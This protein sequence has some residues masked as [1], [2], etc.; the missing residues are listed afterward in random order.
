MSWRCRCFV[1]WQLSS[2]KFHCLNLDVSNPAFDLV[3][4]RS[5]TRSL[6]SAWLGKCG[7]AWASSTTKT[8]WRACFAVGTCAII[9]RDHRRRVGNWKL[10]TMHH[11]TKARPAQDS[12]LWLGLT[13]RRQLM[14]PECSKHQVLSLAKM[15]VVNEQ[16]IFCSHQCSTE[17]SMNK[18]SLSTKFLHQEIRWNYGILPSACFLEISQ[19]LTILILFLINTLLIEKRL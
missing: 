2:N 16:K 19:I 5:L 15:L 8:S 13:S 3:S 14:P 4:P 7:I 1:T 18:L 12:S 6:S 17:C 9:S 10:L 11:G